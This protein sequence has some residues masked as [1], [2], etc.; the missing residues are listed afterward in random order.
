MC[1]QDVYRKE[2]E[3][4]PGGGLLS[5]SARFNHSCLPNVQGSW[6]EGCAE[7]RALRDLSPGEAWGGCGGSLALD[8][9]ELCF[10]YVDCYQNATERQETLALLFK[11]RCRC[12]V[13]RLEPGA[14]LESNER[15]LE[16][17][18]LQDSLQMAAF[19]ADVGAASKVLVPQMLELLDVE[20]HGNSALKS[21]V[22]NLGFLSP[23][24]AKTFCAVEARRGVGG[25]RIGQALGRGGEISRG[26]GLPLPL[27]H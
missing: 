14:L 18:Q 6:A 1:C 26:L 12:P 22:L 10:S 4:L 8:A 17:R 5:R 2:L 11:F 9:K 19:A 21:K 7:W 23:A 25:S 20:L 13:C 3:S 15:R 24:K 27:G 16:L